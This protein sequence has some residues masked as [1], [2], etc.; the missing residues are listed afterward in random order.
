[1]IFKEGTKRGNLPVDRPV[2][3]VPAFEKRQPA[4]DHIIIHFR[5][6]R[7]SKLFFKKTEKFF[8]IGTV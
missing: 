8:K 2:T 3:D 4:P 7:G 1:L 6:G 5:N